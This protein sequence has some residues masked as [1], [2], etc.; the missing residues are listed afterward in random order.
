METFITQPQQEGAAD[1]TKRRV[2]LG[3]E[4]GKGQ[5]GFPAAKE[6]GGF[7]V[8]KETVDRRDIGQPQ[9]DQTSRSL[10]R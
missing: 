1:Q 7:E 10:I 9:L 3:E 6:V 4:C 8:G 5:H 2:D